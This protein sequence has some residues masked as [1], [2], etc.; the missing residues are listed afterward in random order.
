MTRKRLFWAGNEFLNF[1]NRD[2]RSPNMNI[3]F[4][5]KGELYNAYLL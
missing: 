2:F 4:V 3:D 5:R 1:E